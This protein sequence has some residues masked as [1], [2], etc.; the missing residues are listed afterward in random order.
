MRRANTENTIHPEQYFVLKFLEKEYGIMH[1]D[2][3]EML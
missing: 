1:I 3:L 2:K